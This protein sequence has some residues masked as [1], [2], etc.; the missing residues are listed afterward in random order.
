MN[1]LASVTKAVIP[2]EG[3]VPPPAQP[4]LQ[5]SGLNVSLGQLPVLY[6]VSFTVGAGERVGIIGE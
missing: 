2:N 5:V 1:E 6:D 3:A 4:L